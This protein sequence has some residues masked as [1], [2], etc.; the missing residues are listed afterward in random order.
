MLIAQEKATRQSISEAVDSL[1][2]IRPLAK[3]MR[4]A[5][6]GSDFKESACLRNGA[7]QAKMSVSKMI[8]NSGL[9]A[10]MKSPG[11]EEHPG[12]SSQMRAAVASYRCNVRR[13]A[14][15]RF[16]NH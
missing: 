2:Q 9:I 6:L 4:A 13:A 8:S 15:R 3:K 16:G 5:L 10:F 12:G 11:G 14:S 1:H 7:W